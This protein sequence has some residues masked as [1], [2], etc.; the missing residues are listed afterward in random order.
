[1]NFKTLYKILKNQ[2][3]QFIYF[4]SKRSLLKNYKLFYK[5]F[6]FNLLLI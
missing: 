1:M 6:F 3:L 2:N 4:I 5:L